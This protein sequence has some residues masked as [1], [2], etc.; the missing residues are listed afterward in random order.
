MNGA[1]VFA[2][3]GF[4]MFAM[5]LWAIMAF[6]NWQEKR[7]DEKREVREAERQNNAPHGLS[8]DWDRCE[9]RSK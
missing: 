7:N 1:D 6:A 3:V 9:G 8:T 5:G 4:V 2:L